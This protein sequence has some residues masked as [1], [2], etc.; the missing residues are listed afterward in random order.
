[1]TTL[2]VFTKIFA[3][4]SKKKESDV[5]QWLQINICGDALKTISEPISLDEA[6]AL[7]TEYKANPEAMIKTISSVFTVKD[8]ALQT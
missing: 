4:F 7:Y 3:D 6:Q 5:K 1:M 2:D 8:K